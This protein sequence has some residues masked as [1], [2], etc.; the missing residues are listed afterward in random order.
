MSAGNK[1]GYL[2]SDVR[3][4]LA[5][6]KLDGSNKP[7]V[8]AA[9]SAGYAGDAQQLVDDYLADARSRSGASYRPSAMSAIG[10][11]ILGLGVYWIV[12]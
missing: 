7:S 6:L 3:T 10:A 12:C 2:S 5:R 8:V 4:A 1:W 9:V 11:V